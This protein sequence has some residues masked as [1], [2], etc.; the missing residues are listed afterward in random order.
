MKFPCP[1][2][3]GD[4]ISLRC[5]DRLGHRRRLWTSNLFRRPGSSKGFSGS[6]TTGE[7]V[8]V[9]VITVWQVAWLPRIEESN[10]VTS[11]ESAVAKL[12]YL[13]KF[14]DLTG[15]QRGKNNFCRQQSWTL[16]LWSALAI[17]E[18]HSTHLVRCRKQNKEASP[19]AKSAK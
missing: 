7:L 14:Q 3:P 8:Q 19:A 15:R 10:W 11:T 1:F 4:G 16:A 12:D 2:S 5:H 6:T 13:T 9:W 17:G 18:S